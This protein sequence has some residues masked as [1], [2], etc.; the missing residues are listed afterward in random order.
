MIMIT[1][2]I[3]K[4]SLPEEWAHSH[5]TWKEVNDHFS[6]RALIV[7]EYN[8]KMMPEIVKAPLKFEAYKTA[9]P[10]FQ[11]KG[12]TAWVAKPPS[13]MYMSSNTTCTR[14]CFATQKRW[15]SATSFATQN[16]IAIHRG[17]S[18]GRF[19][20]APEN[21]RNRIEESGK[22]QKLNTDFGDGK[23]RFYEASLVKH[24]TK[25]RIT[26]DQIR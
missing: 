15:C 14:W 23:C 1:T 5:V 22:F 18:G 10:I 25:A 16:T 21:F 2:K 8:G 9:R 12:I 24:W 20:P 4:P 7:E 11:N 6:L 26:Y 3:D 17:R 19:T 13:T